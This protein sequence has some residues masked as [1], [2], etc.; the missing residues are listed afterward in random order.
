LLQGIPVL[1]KEWWDP[2]W[3]KDNIQPKLDSPTAPG[4]EEMKPVAKPLRKRRR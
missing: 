3:I 2:K 1:P 4:T